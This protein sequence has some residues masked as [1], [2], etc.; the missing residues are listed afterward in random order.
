[1]ILFQ[2]K[3]DEI[4]D[5]LSQTATKI[6]KALHFVRTLAD[7]FVHFP[8]GHD[9]RAQLIDSGLEIQAALA[10]QLDAMR[11]ALESCGNDNL[12]CIPKSAELN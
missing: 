1:M 6:E 3:D 2:L 9:E 4:R 5:N 7:G 11:G 12:A 8:K 10:D